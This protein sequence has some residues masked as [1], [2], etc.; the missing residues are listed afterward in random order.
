MPAPAMRLG[1]GGATVHAGTRLS[2]SSAKEA[3]ATMARTPIPVQ[4]QG[5]LVSSISRFLDLASA[6]PV[7]TVRR[8]NGNPG[9]DSTIARVHHR[10]DASP[11]STPGTMARALLVLLL[12]ALLPAASARGVDATSAP[13]VPP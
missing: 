7:F 4:M 2:A 6:A 1:A 11:R 13:P 9:P 10:L 5:P 8:M 3:P 12:V